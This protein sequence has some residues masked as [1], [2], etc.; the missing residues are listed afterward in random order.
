MRVILLQLPLQGHDFFFSRENI[1]LAAACLKAIGAEEGIE[2]ELVPRSLMSYGSDQA[3]LQFLLDAKPD[4]VGMSCYLWNVERSLFLGRALKDHLPEC[5]VVLGGPEVTPDNEYLIGSRGFD[6]GI[7]GEGEALWK[8]LL[9]SYP[10]IPEAPGLLLRGKDGRLRLMKEGR[11]R[12]HALNRWPSPFLSGALDSQLDGVLWLETVRGCVHRCAYCYYHKQ[13]PRLRPVSVD[14]VLEEVRR[15]RNRGLKEI[16]F[17]DPCFT[18]RPDLESLLD[19]LE[20]INGDGRLRF[21]AECN[22]E[23]IEPGI[24]RKMGRAGFTDLEVGL[25]SVNGGTLRRIHRRLRPERF[26]NGVRFLQ[27][28]G[29]KV[30]VDLIAGLPGDTLP[31]MRRSIDWVLEQEAYDF[32]MLYPL[33][34]LPATELR[35]R[36]RELGLDAMSRPPYLVTR[37][38]GLSAREISAA[39]RY[40]EECMEEDISPLELPPGL[41]GPPEVSAVSEGLRHTLYLNTPEQAR[42]LLQGKDR[43]AYGLTLNITEAMLREPALWLPIL[44]DYL[45]S[46]PYSLLSVEVPPGVFPEELEPLWQLARERRHPIDS[47]YTVTH[48]PYRNFLLFS[49]ER[50]ILWKWPDPR[51]SRPVEL[52]GGQEVPF[53]PTCVATGPEETLPSWFLDHIAKRY[54]SPPEIRL[55]E[56]ADDQA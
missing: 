38:P 39:F 1:P 24:A 11:P 52:P 56:P 22:A 49:R 43:N 17:L 51:E 13:S 9:A 41:G 32:L 50:G 36:A 26:L 18:R 10:R 42:S 27:E 54:P 28:S 29:I 45:K 34:L 35:L 16:V 14:R 37:G 53:H 6:I 31:D 21:S 55:W 15:A 48:T 4:I 5:A 2:I 33:S 3:L 25:Q 30:K 47:D 40:Y 19:A 12:H 46:N 23:D 7:M 20:E 44:K 8:V